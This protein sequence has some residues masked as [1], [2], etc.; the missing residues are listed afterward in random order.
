ME[1][2]H[3]DTCKR[4]GLHGMG[5]VGKTTLV[6][7]I[8]KKAKE[9]NIFNNIVMTTVS[10]TPEIRIIQGEIA[11]FLNLKLDEESNTARAIRI[12]LRIK[13]L[14]KI[15]IIMDDVWTDIN[16]EAIGIPSCDDHKGCKMLL[17]TRSEHVCN[18]MCF[19]RKI[20]LNLLLEKESLALMRKITG[21]VDDC[22]PLNDVVLKVVEECKCLPIAIITIG[23]ALIGKSLDEWNV[24]MHQLRRSRLVDIEGVEEEKNAYVG[25]KWSYDQLKR[26]TKLCFLLCSLFPKDYNIPIEELTRYAMGL[27]E[28]KDFHLLEDTRSQV[29]ATINSLKDSSLLLKGIGK[30]Y[31]KMHDMVRDVGLWIASKGENEFKL[32]ACTHLDKNISFEGVT[33]ISLMASNTKQYP[34]KLV[35]PTLNILLL[36]RNE[37][38]KKISDTLFEGMNC[39]KVLRL[40]ENILSS[41]SLQFLTNLQSLYLKNCDFIDNLSSLGKL[42]RLETLSFH[43][44]GMD[45]LPNELGETGSLRMLDLTDCNKLEQIPPNLIQRLSRL[46]ELII[47]LWHFKNWDVE[48]KNAEISNANL[49]EL[50]SLPSLVLLSLRLDLK[51]LPQ[52]FVFPY[53]QRYYISINYPYSFNFLP[54]NPTFCDSRTLEIK[55]LNA[56]SMNA[57]NKLFCTVEYIC[58]ESCETECI[59]DTTKGNYSVMFANLVKLHLQDM[60]YLRIICEGPNQNVIFSN[61][62]ILVV[63][64]CTRLNSLFSLSHAQSLIKLKQLHLANCNELKKIISEEGMVLESR[65]QPLYVTNPIFVSCFEGTKTS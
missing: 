31:V 3:D 2:L 23:K 10:R 61:L 53:L 21:V 6:K 8:Y 36:G 28:Y 29:R 41:Q 47:D 18:L 55:D 38:F 40:E 37:G 44:C 62:T 39:L 19:Q 26:K 65:N 25:L 11:G 16:L 17:A 56:F 20:P 45:A 35:C 27:E 1:A 34:D 54:N 22:Q 63:Y 13:S 30:G 60:S 58:I 46:E 50:N 4:I 5:G 51:R 15:L 52:G 48:G 42:K 43:R 64:G 7:E 12:C 24:T 14:E 57:F 9:L 49:S 33:V 59:V 32:I